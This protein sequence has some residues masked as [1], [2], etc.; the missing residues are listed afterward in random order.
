MAGKL[1]R[2]VSM[3]QYNEAVRKIEKAGVNTPQES[4]RDRSFYHRAL[5][6]RRRKAA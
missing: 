2:R 5:F 6:A 3:R 1:T 4:I